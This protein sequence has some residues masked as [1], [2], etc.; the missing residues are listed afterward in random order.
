[1]K[2]NIFNVFLQEKPCAILNVLRNS[3]GSCASE[4]ARKI[5]CTYSHV[6]KILL[7]LEKE[8]FINFEKQGRIHKID[9]TEKGEKIAEHIEKIKE[10][11]MENVRS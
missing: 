6:H 10:L 4:I 7:F 5:D 1:M 9:L 8:E 2:S 11:L 3:Q